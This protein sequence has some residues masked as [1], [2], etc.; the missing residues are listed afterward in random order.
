MEL[1]LIFLVLFPLTA[2]VFVNTFTLNVNARV[3]LIEVSFLIV[4]S[5]LNL[6]VAGTESPKFLD[7][8]SKSVLLVFHFRFDLNDQLVELL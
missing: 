5:L 1:A 2:D 3:D 4:V 8:R 6:R 7:F